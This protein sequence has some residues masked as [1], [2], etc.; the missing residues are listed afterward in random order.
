MRVIRRGVSVIWNKDTAIGKLFKRETDLFSKYIKA[1][2][3][4]ISH[5]QRKKLQLCQWRENQNRV[6]IRSTCITH[7]FQYM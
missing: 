3:S 1:N 4:Q 7:S 5:C 2:E 6:G